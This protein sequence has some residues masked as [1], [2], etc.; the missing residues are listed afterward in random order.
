MESHR[1]IEPRSNCL[2]G[3]AN[4]W[5]DSD[6]LRSDFPSRPTTRRDL[7]PARLEIRRLRIANSRLVERSSDG[8]TGSPRPPLITTDLV[9]ARVLGHETIAA[10]QAG[11]ILDRGH[12]LT[13]DSLV[14]E[15]GHATLDLGIDSGLARGPPAYAGRRV[16]GRIS[17]VGRGTST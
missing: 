9:P 5:V 11:R 1:P 10:W 17:R 16:A 7:E 15:P 6:P 8:R 12:G 3:D 4:Q 2:R 14:V 13:V